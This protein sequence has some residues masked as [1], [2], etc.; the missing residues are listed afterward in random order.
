MHW[1]RCRSPEAKA[2]DDSSI[3]QCQRLHVCPPWGPS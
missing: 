2:I 1:P 3:S